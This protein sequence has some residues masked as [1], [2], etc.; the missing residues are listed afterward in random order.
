MA[1]FT[2]SYIFRLIDQFTPGS[3]V[4]AGAAGRLAKNF[5]ALGMAAS[6]VGVAVAGVFTGAV[7]EAIKFEDK[8]AEIRKV[9]PNMTKDDMWQMGNRVMKLAIWSGEAK[10]NIADIFAAG[11]RMGIH[12]QKALEKFAETITKVKVAWDGV[13]ARDAG[14]A[15]A[16]I[17]SK[18]FGKMDPVEAQN[19]MIGVADAI[20]YLGQNTA[21]VKPGELLKFFQRGGNQMGMIGF[22][23]E[24]AAAYGAAALTAGTPS[25]AM[26][27]TLTRSTMQRLRTNA[28]FT[29][30]GRAALNELKMTQAQL[31]KTLNMRGPEAIMDLMERIE[32]VPAERRGMVLK[33]LLGDQRATSQFENIIKQLPEFK[34]ALATTSV[35][36]AER[37]L[38]DK[39]FVEW[40]EKVRPGQLKALQEATARGVPLSEGSVDQEFKTRLE[41]M[42]QQ[43]NRAGEAWD[44]LLVKLGKP[45]LPAGADF[46]SGLAGSLEKFGNVLDN[47]PQLAKYAGAGALGAAG[48]GGLMLLGKAFAWATGISSAF[49]GLVAL[50]TVTLGITLVAAGIGAAY[51]LYENWPTVKAWAAEKLTFNIEWPKIPDW[52]RGLVDDRVKGGFRRQWNEML[53]IPNR[54][55]EDQ[56]PSAAFT[57]LADRAVLGGANP[58]AVGGWDQFV[59]RMDTMAANAQSTQNQLLQTRPWERYGGPGTPVPSTFTPT[60]PTTIESKVEVDVKPVTFA[61]ATITVDARGMGTGALQANPTDGRGTAT[62]QIGSPTNAMGPR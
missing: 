15:M 27:G 35:K 7:K 37:F 18:F 32:R 9:V 49:A 54:P 12:D 31:G 16:T 46:F 19:R 60:A 6:G 22:T 8:L 44:A 53:G 42:K 51:W 26:E 4:I 57:K 62:S 3:V 56:G 11:A 24:E 14:E 61:P 55:L 30:K 33:N 21:A 47:N 40:M 10:E 45:V 38:K 25:G 39:D 17:S 34:R 1:T 20:N 43:M 29:A 36:W 28:M 41:T 23:P 59:A 48:L 13:T 2:A 50:G 5:S 58:A 52:V